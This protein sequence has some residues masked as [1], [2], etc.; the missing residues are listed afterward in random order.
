M[1]EAPLCFIPAPPRPG[2]RPDKASW[3]TVRRLLEKMTDCNSYE[4]FTPHAPIQWAP[5][6]GLRSDSR[7]RALRFTRPHEVG[8]IGGCDASTPEKS[9]TESS[10]K[11]RALGPD[12]WERETLLDTF[13]C[14]GG[15]EIA[16][17]E[18]SKNLHDNYFRLRFEGPCVVTEGGRRGRGWRARGREEERDRLR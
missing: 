18:F 4:P 8:C 13:V 1:S 10:E 2:L 6:S 15:V 17:I 5:Y 3:R 14:M 16:K 11:V 7:L 12:C 9:A